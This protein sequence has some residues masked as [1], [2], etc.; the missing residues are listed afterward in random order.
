MGFIG[1]KGFGRWNDKSRLSG[2]L[3]YR[4]ESE[5]KP[6]KQ[7]LFGEFSSSVSRRVIMDSFEPRVLLSADLMPIAGTISAP[8]ERD[9]YSI[10]VSEPAKVTFDSLTDSQLR[11]RLLGSDGKEVSTSRL[12]RSDDGTNRTQPPVLDLVRGTYTLVVDGA[13]GQTGEYNFR[14]LDLADAMPID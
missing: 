2:L 5:D 14:L 1:A 9:S 10:T 7:S 6:A 12:D 3:E 8:G 13:E 4:K 11:W